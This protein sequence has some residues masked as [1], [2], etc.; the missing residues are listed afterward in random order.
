MYFFFS[1]VAFTAFYLLLHLVSYIS[2]TFLSYP[3]SYS[4][5]Q[6]INPY[7]S[8]SPPSSPSFLRSPFQYHSFVPSPDLSLTTLTS[9]QSFLYTFSSLLP[10]FTSHFSSSSRPSS[11]N[12]LSR[13]PSFSASPASHPGLGA[14]LTVLPLDESEDCSATSSADP[15]NCRLTHEPHTGFGKPWRH[16]RGFSC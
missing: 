11:S 1:T 12:S 15:R 16:T 6:P 13:L 3:P 14:P 8:R 9:Y 7:S 10:M 2:S 5:L 4:K